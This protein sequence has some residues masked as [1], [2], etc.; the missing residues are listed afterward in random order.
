MCMMALPLLSAG[1]SI[2]QAG[3]GYSAETQK[4]NAQNAAWQSNFNNSI[5][6]QE[7]R[8]DSINNNTRQ[9]HA[10]ADADLMAKQ[11][12]SLQKEATARVAAGQ[13]G[14][15]GLSTNAIL[16]D[17]L[18]RQGRQADAVQQN[19]EMKRDHNGDELIA[20]NDQ[21]ISRVNSMQR[22]APVSA[23]PFVFQ[24]L[25]GVVGASTMGARMQFQENRGS[26]N[27][28]ATSNLAEG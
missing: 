27:F 3:A 4:A 17:Y 22:A 15:S 14:V 12:D 1:L 20:T 7:N 26:G 2:A 23:T 24:A 19:F 5:K 16:G 10:S 18:A 8:Y 6:A 13:S 9:E 11:V 28:N 25:G 21:A